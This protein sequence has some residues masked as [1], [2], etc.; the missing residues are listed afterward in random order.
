MGLLC[1]LA[2]YWQTSKLMHMAFVLVTPHACTVSSV[3][4]LTTDL[5]QPVLRTNQTTHL[6]ELSSKPRRRSKHPTAQCLLSCICHTLMTPSPPTPPPPPP[7]PPTLPPLTAASC[8]EHITAADVPAKSFCPLFCKTQAAQTT[9]RK[10]TGLSH[11]PPDMSRQILLTT[12]A[13]PCTALQA[14]EK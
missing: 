4:D 12:D 8:Y 9:Q 7:P 13:R 10:V 2:E 6:T 5:W 3:H 1:G 11:H 14:T